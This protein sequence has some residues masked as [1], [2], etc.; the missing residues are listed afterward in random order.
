[1]NTWNVSQMLMKLR[2]DGQCG[3]ATITLHEHHPQNERDFTANLYSRLRASG[4]T[5]YQIPRLVRM[6]RQMELNATFKY[7]TASV[8]QLPWDPDKVSEEVTLWWLD[9]ETYRPLEKKSWEAI[10]TGRARL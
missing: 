2:Y 4:L 1:M 6:L 7:A 8:K 10:S 3:S 5:P 9:G